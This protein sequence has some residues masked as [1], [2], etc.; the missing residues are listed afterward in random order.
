VIVAAIVALVVG[1]LR[2]VLDRIRHPHGK[3]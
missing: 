1:V 2:K 3:I